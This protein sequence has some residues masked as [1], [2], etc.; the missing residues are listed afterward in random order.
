MASY[1]RKEYRNDERPP[2]HNWFT[3]S[4]MFTVE[5]AGI[6]YL[7]YRMGGPHGKILDKLKDHMSVVRAKDSYEEWSR[8]KRDINITDFRGTIDTGLPGEKSI[9]KSSSIPSMDALSEWGATEL[10]VDTLT[11]TSLINSVDRLE[12]DIQSFFEGDTAGHSIDSLKKLDIYKNHT[13]SKVTGN[14]EIS[15]DI[16]TTKLKL[17]TLKEHA[18]SQGRYIEGAPLIDASD[19]LFAEDPYANRTKINQLHKFTMENDK[20]YADKYKDSVEK[21]IRNFRMEVTPQV[22][23]DPRIKS[24]VVDGEIIPSSRLVN[25]SRGSIEDQIR[26]VG[27]ITEIKPDSSTALYLNDTTVPMARNVV[28]QNL[29]KNIDHSDIKVRYSQYLP[30]LKKIANQLE[31]LKSMHPDNIREVFIKDLKYSVGEDIKRKYMVVGIR[32]KVQNFSEHLIELPIPIAEDGRVPNITGIHGRVHADVQYTTGEA[33]RMSDAKAVNATKDYFEHV[34]KMLNDVRSHGITE[35]PKKYEIDRLSDL[36]KVQAKTT[37]LYGEE[38]DFIRSKQVRTVPNEYFFNTTAARKRSRVRALKVGIDSIKT[39]RKLKTSAS[40]QRLVVMDLETI[41]FDA[42]SPQFVSTDPTTGIW[43]F[44]MIES[45]ASGMILN[46][47]KATS[48]HIL[49]E[50]RLLIEELKRKGSLREVLNSG[51]K[52]GLRLKGFAEFTKKTT[53]LRDD[54]DSLV[55]FINDVK[56]QA[57]SNKNSLS[58][59][60]RSSINSSAD[61]A[62]YIK[63]RMEEVVNN[64]RKAG[65][66]VT[67]VTTNGLDFDLRLIETLTGSSGSLRKDVANIDVQK[68][69]K[70]MTVGMYDSPSASLNNLVDYWMNKGKSGRDSFISFDHSPDKVVRAL[71][72]GKH[73]T[74]SPSKGRNVLDYL[75]GKLGKKTIAHDALSDSVATLG[76]MQMMKNFHDT[77]DFYL[78]KDIDAYVNKLQRPTDNLKGLLELQ[79]MELPGN[80]GKFTFSLTSSNGSSKMIGGNLDAAH[81]YSLLAANPPGRNL[82]QLGRS[83]WIRKDTIDTKNRDW[84][85]RDKLSDHMVLKAEEWML[86]DVGAMKNRLVNKM[87]FHTAYMYNMWGGNQGLNLI[88]KDALEFTTYSQK[89]ISLEDV[90]K[91]SVIG[92]QITDMYN[93]IDNEAKKIARATNV[94]F[95]KDGGKT[96]AEQ[97]NKAARNVR[98]E[99]EKFGTFPSL[100][101]NNPITMTTKEGG[102][103][104]KFNNTY[105]G[106]IVSIVQNT[107][108]G[109]KKGTVSYLAEV[110]LEASGEHL[111]TAIIN[112]KGVAGLALKLNVKATSLAYREHGLKHPIQRWSSFDFLSK[113]MWG[114][115]RQ[116]ML[117]K[118]WAIANDIKSRSKRGT[119]EYNRANKSLKRLTNILNSSIGYRVNADGTHTF[120]PKDTTMDPNEL[121]KRQSLIKATDILDTYSMMGQEAT[122][123]KKQIEA[124]YG[125]HGNDM[126]EGRKNI[127]KAMAQ[128]LLGLRSEAKEFGKATQQAAMIQQQAALIRLQFVERHLRKKSIIKGGISEKIWER[129]PTTMKRYI[130]EASVPIFMQIVTDPNDPNG[131]GRPGYIAPASVT[132]SNQAHNV[133]TYNKRIKLRRA[134]YDQI[135]VKGNHFSDSTKSML[136]NAI[137]WKKDPKLWEVSKKYKELRNGITNM[138]VSKE[139]ASDHTLDF[140]QIDELISRKDTM[141][142]ITRDLKAAADSGNTNILGKASKAMDDIKKNIG[143]LVEDELEDSVQEGVAMMNLGTREF[144][145]QIENRPNWLHISEVKNQYSKLATKKKGLWYLPGKFKK[146]EN[147][148][149]KTYGKNFEFNL[150][151]LINEINAS[152]TSKDPI[153]KEAFLSFFNMIEEAHIQKGAKSTERMLS[154]K[155]V[156]G[157][158]VVSMGGFLL[159]ANVYAEN[160]THRVQGGYG[161]KTDMMRAVSDTIEAYHIFQREMINGRQG[162]GKW[163]QATKQWLMMIEHTMS[164]VKGSPVFQANNMVFPQGFEATFH[165]ADHIMNKAHGVLRELESGVQGSELKEFFGKNRKWTHGRLRSHLKSITDMKMN[166]MLASRST[167]FNKDMTVQ[168]ANGNNANLMQLVAKAEGPMKKLYKEI[169]SG[170]ATMPGGVMF[171]FP[172]APEGSIPGHEGPM[173]LVHDEVARMLGIDKTKVYGVEAVYNMLKADNDNDKL[174]VILKG[175]STIEEADAIRAE[176]AKVLSKYKTLPHM[177]SFYDSFNDAQFIDSTFERGGQRYARVARVDYAGDAQVVLDEVVMKNLPIYD[178]EQKKLRMGGLINEKMTYAAQLGNSSKALERHVQ[179]HAVSAYS[180]S[181]IGLWNNLITQRVHEMFMATPGLAKHSTEVFAMLGSLE[182]GAGSLLQEAAI[183]AVKHSSGVEETYRMAELYKLWND[184]GRASAELYKKGRDHWIKSTEG[185][186]TAIRERAGSDFDMIMNR[187]MTLD[188]AKKYDNRFARFIKHEHGHMAG[189]KGFGLMD[190]AQYSMFE[191]GRVDDKLTETMK[192]AMSSLEIGPGGEKL[193]IFSDYIND[194]YLGTGLEDIVSK[195]YKSV[196]TDIKRPMKTFGK[197]AGIAALGYLGVN[198]FRANSLSNSANPFDMFVDL[199]TDVEG[200][201]RMFGSDLELPRKMP[202]DMVDASFSNSA[203]IEMNDNRSSYK[204]AKSNYLNSVIENSTLGGYFHSNTYQFKSRP[205]TTYSNRSSRIGPFGNS[206]IE[207]RSKMF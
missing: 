49:R 109:S 61:F 203:Y 176:Q 130:D 157:K 98:A 97:W 133:P 172:V 149:W 25:T 166:T 174:A 204:S 91:D 76:V 21:V 147:G 137:G 13:F 164:P 151:N 192:A 14:A 64:A 107:S 188:K 161:P 110:M 104:R 140:K 2:D 160:I 1:D 71:A 152:H 134:Y 84:M 199:G 183:G 31:E 78:L 201:S 182:H 175:F 48:D 69:T 60:H 34:Y 159:P 127:R 36:F 82:A 92:S 41:N 74:L 177:Q 163:H 153:K 72:D 87:Q 145:E 5:L 138:I 141:D 139:F 28:E 101:P 16:I 185:Q 144:L 187:S 17:E 18:S 51:S 195:K 148:E 143:D 162:E 7:A 65:E 50:N 197:F 202:L 19:P 167:I 128:Q 94:N 154:V 156:N 63:R 4:S 67:F 6:G 103:I 189:K 146:F 9:V 47:E 115:L 32:A 190:W 179:T 62:S 180:K 100:D 106:K 33:F 105:P 56:A 88:T 200:E 120:G 85:I 40:K 54:Y 132:L 169:K 116:S 23:S 96:T 55:S 194:R 150:D 129:D 26:A 22:L 108:P 59:K 198:F 42:N 66:T 93:R 181:Q 168:F 112:D 24:K 114:S 68:Y 46:A 29:Q 135:M 57:G 95:D 196:I 99:M 184:P 70:A 12:N 122:F 124:W 113:G 186:P 45:D 102:R 3:R 20:L 170:R 15:K 206:D 11:P 39:M 30:Q 43:Q 58:S 191:K 171:R 10:G 123:T 79:G 126:W 117:E 165:T 205:R 155:E 178:K 111:N 81:M 125:Y 77:S 53:G 80:L 44:G 38:R 89:F 8:K 119:P 37:P 35:N 52:E 193:N 142:A 83:T 121:L 118:G 131:Y 27:G 207:R 75:K 90:P 173:Q 136:D 158:H 73:I 86:Q